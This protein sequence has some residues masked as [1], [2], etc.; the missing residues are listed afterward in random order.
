MCV[1]SQ[2][3]KDCDFSIGGLQR[4]LF[5]NYNNYVWEN[6]KLNNQETILTDILIGLVWHE[7]DTRVDAVE[8]KESQANSE[9]GKLL[10]HTINWY[11]QQMQSVK[12]IPIKDL[13]K[14]R[15]IVIHQDNNDRYWISGLYT[16]YKCTQ[17]DA[18][19]GANKGDNGYSFT[20]KS[21]SI[22]QVFSVSQKYIDQKVEGNINNAEYDSEQ[23]SI[24]YNI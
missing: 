17:F 16:P 23:Y 1:L 15:F 18:G 14:G 19:T 11:I 4:L 24:Q 21:L 13:R 9:Q 12:S 20:F 5:A 10:E 22:N 8:F 7:L 6:I 2:N 3:I